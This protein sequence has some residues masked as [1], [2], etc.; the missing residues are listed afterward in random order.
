M[1]N[2]EKTYEIYTDASFDNK[3]KLGTYSVTITQ[4]NKVIKAFGKPCEK[5]LSNSVESEVFAIF[6]AMNIIESQLIK[7]KNPK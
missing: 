7:E 4:E 5:R 2:E 6:Q 1:E 3:T